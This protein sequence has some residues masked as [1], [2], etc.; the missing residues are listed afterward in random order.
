[1]IGSLARLR[2]RRSEVQQ[3][4]AAARARLTA[5]RRM[6]ALEVE[7]AR[8]RHP[9]LQL[10]RHLPWLVPLGLVAIATGGRKGIAGRVAAGIPVG[11][12]ATRLLAALVPLLLRRLD[13]R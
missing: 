1:M 6:A 13:R 7:L 10:V 4:I 8:A 9:S 2:A 11:G 5:R 12:A 3:E